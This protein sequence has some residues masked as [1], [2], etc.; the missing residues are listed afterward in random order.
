MT[1]IE[2][3]VEQPI[4]GGKEGSRRDQRIVRERRKGDRR[5]EEREAIIVDL[6]HLPT[7]YEWMAKHSECD[8]EWNGEE[9]SHRDGLVLIRP[10][11]HFGDHAFTEVVLGRLSEGQ[12]TGWLVKRRVLQAHGLETSIAKK[13]SVIY[14]GSTREWSEFQ[15]L[16]STLNKIFPRNEPSLRSLYEQH[17]EKLGVAPEFADSSMGYTAT[18]MHE[19]LS[20]VQY[21]PSSPEGSCLLVDLM[22][23]DEY[24]DKITRDLITVG[25]DGQP[26]PGH[27]DYDSIDFDELD[28]SGESDPVVD[29]LVS[30]LETDIEIEDQMRMDHPFFEADGEMKIAGVQYL[31]DITSQEELFGATYQFIRAYK[32]A[33]K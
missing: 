9:F 12:D 24:M 14:L 10:P 11:N 15:E 30:R 16:M 3:I 22:G 20:M 8:F 29:G 17:F 4:K 2:N 6:E 19:G 23:Q 33:T 26:G 21:L 5:Q 31:K 28:E 18:F 7:A 27:H 13:D 1:D 32:D 25:Y